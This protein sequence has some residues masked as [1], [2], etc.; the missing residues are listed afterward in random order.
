MQ[1]NQGH[2]LVAARTAILCIFLQLSPTAGPLPCFIKAHFLHV[3]DT[4]YE[5]SS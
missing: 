2:L 1:E 5:I 3:Y 4:K